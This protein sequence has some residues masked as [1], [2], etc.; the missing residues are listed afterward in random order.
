MAVMAV[1]AV[2]VMAVETVAVMAVEAVAVVV[3]VPSPTI[4]EVGVGEAL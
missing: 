3:R 2:A 1:E 4:P